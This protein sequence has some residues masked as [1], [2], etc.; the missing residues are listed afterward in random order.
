MTFTLIMLICFFV[1]IV[2]QFCQDL[3]VIRVPRYITDEGTIASVDRSEKTKKSYDGEP[4]VKGRRTI[5]V[6]SGQARARGQAHPRIHS[7]YVYGCAHV[8]VRGV[9]GRLMRC[10]AAVYNG[11][12][13]LCYTLNFY[14]DNW[15]WKGKY[16]LYEN[17]RSCKKQSSML[18]PRKRG[19]M[20]VP[21]LVC[22]SV[23]LFVCYQ[24][25]GLRGSAS[26]VLTATGFVNGRWQFSTPHRI[27]T[28]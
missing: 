23:C 27:N 28:P 9:N 26:P 17:P 4:I 6:D 24:D 22:L 8:S 7:H 3:C 14:M 2:H 12:H 13:F 5:G 11:H 20:F 25:H 10:I 19:I 21:A 16:N 15:I 18:S 1:N